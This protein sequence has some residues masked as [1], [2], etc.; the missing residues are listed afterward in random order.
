M[1]PADQ[2]YVLSSVCDMK[3]IST[4]ILHVYIWP[5]WI[6]LYLF[7]YHIRP[8]RHISCHIHIQVRFWPSYHA[9]SPDKSMGFCVLGMAISKSGNYKTLH[10]LSSG[11]SWA[12]LLSVSRS[13][14]YRHRPSIWKQLKTILISRANQIWSITIV[15]EIG[16]SCT[17][18]VKL[19][20]ILLQ[21][22]LCC[23]PAVFCCCCTPCTHF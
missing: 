9:G 21:S 19:F 15:S 22:Y 12:V 1:A 6:G 18:D 2:I 11:I 3:S 10:W 20:M 7:N 16:Y 23:T 17:Q 14:M 5:N 4:V 13:A 8:S